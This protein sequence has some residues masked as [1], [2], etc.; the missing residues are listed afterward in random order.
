MIPIVVGVSNVD[1]LYLLLVE[2]VIKLWL[3]RIKLES[4][5]E[6]ILKAKNS[7][8]ILVVLI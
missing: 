6:E 4:M 3:S 8:Q 2:K 1:Y 7:Q 5:L